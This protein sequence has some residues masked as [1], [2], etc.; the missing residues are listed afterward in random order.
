MRRARIYALLAGY[1]STCDA[2]SIAA[3]DPEGT[4]AAKATALSLHHGVLT[5]I[6]NL[7][8]PGHN[9]VLCLARLR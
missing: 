6:I 2:S 4:W 1:G 8:T 7:E 9:C 3:P 5:S